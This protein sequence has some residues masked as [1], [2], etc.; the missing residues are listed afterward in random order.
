[1]I[2]KQDQN[3][4]VERE[5]IKKVDIFNLKPN[6]NEVK[7]R[8]QRYD[9]TSF[10]GLLA[11]ASII[12]FYL[13]N[14]LDSYFDNILVLI[15]N[16]VAIAYTIIRFFIP[17]TKYNFTSKGIVINE[18]KTIYWSDIK[19]I[20]VIE[21]L[22]KEKKNKCYGKKFRFETKQNTTEEIN[23]NNYVISSSS[24]DLKN[25]DFR[26]ESIYKHQIVESILVSFYHKYGDKENL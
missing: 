24:Q 20:T 3:D 1:M 10:I 26:L 21:R 5:V 17:F 25:A 9:N 8:K 15:V 2:K 16:I 4:D 7:I 6:C 18:N 12:Y 11:L 23:L 22:D 14:R 13:V 19:S